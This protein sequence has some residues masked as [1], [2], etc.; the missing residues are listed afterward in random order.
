MSLSILIRRMILMVAGI[1][2]A[3]AFSGSARAQ[4]PADTFWV[5]YFT[6]NG[7][8]GAPNAYVQVVNPGVA[9]GKLCASVYVWRSD[10]ELSE[11]CTCP[12]TANGLLT[13]TVNV[14][15]ANPGDHPPVAASGSIDVISDS[16]C[17]PTNPSP[18]PDLRIWATHVTPDTATGKFDVTE[19]PALATTLSSGEQS[20]AASRCAFLTSNGSGAGRCDNSN[21]AFNICNE[22]ASSSSE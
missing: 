12:V 19:T 14:A 18:T 8:T 6:N 4:A 5:T 20:E 17:D 13:F 1:A 10:Q 15:A 22:F 2:A 3:L 9:S 7:V 16:N 21:P 11:C